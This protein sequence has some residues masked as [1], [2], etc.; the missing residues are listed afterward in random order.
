MGT[1]AVEAAININFKEVFIRYDARVWLEL[2]N[3][4]Y[5]LVDEFLESRIHHRISLCRKL[6]STLM[7]FMYLTERAL[8]YSLDNCKPTS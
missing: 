4:F 5:I 8:A 3:S 6:L 7:H 2:L 1:A